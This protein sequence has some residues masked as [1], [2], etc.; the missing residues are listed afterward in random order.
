M[1]TLGIGELARRTGLR[2]SAIRYYESLGLVNPD[3][4]G[5]WRRF[6][7]DAVEHLQV[8]RMARALGFSID[9]IRTLFN[10]FSPETPPPERWRQLAHEKLPQLDSLIRHA[11]AMKRM[12]EV[13]LS[14]N[15]ARIEDCFIEDCAGVNTE[16]GS[17][18]TFVPLRAQPASLRHARPVPAR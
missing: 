10:G 8:I 4:R 13:G 5:S 3:R 18:L 12:L 1:E 11:S 15:C 9:E 7:P 14:C 2:P 6:T 17:G 16:A